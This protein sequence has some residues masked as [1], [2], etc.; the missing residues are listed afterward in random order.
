MAAAVQYTNAGTVEFLVDEALG[1][2]FI[3][4]NTR[5]QVEH[6]VTEC[7]T[8]VDLVAEQIRLAE[9]A[10]LAWRQ[11]D[12]VR[13]GAAL[14]CRIY[15]ENPAK[16]FLPSPGHITAVHFPSGPGV[17]VDSVL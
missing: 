7:V 9:G 17:R 6:T 3:E 16:N 13:R 8:G 4:M 10:P 14:E 15:A 5:L 2:Y 12:L 11:E 1:W